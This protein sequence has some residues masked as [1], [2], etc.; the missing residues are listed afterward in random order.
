M[1]QYLKVVIAILA[2][3]L[4]FYFQIVSIDAFITFT[5]NLSAVDI[6]KLVTL[7]FLLVIGTYFRWYFCSIFF[8]IHIPKKKLI[9]VSSEAYTFG[10]IIP[11]QLG[12]DGWRILQFKDL[13]E[14]RF[15]SK[16]LAVTIVEK[17]ISLLA[18]LIVFILFLFILFEVKIAFYKIAFLFI[19]ILFGSILFFKISKYLIQKKLQVDIQ[20]G[21]TWNLLKIFIFS[22]SLNL[23]ACCLIFFISQ[24]MLGDD[25][26][27]FLR[28]SIAM[29]ASNISAAIPITP[30]GVGL[31]E[32]L[33]SKMLSIMGEDSKT[34]LH[35]TS[36]LIYRIFNIL[37][38]F[39]VYVSSTFITS[40]KWRLPIE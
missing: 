36:Y 12:I 28:T 14:T 23:G 31:A 26:L 11:G 17:I 15:K 10:Q 3:Y 35:G 19:F 21:S 40:L 30:N 4:L 39:C 13:D 7:T 8:G 16:L 37:G 2:I 27:S 25:G 9:K 1:R 33:Y 32:F 18:Q 34:V 20:N 24:T 38:H 6:L 22:I 5:S 29:L